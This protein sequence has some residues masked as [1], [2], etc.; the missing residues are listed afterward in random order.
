M[1]HR[2]TSRHRYG[3]GGHYGRDP[4]KK[5]KRK[6]SAYNRFVKAKMK[7][8][9]SMGQA[10]KAWTSQKKGGAAHKSK[11]NKRSYTKSAGKSHKSRKAHR[12]PKVNFKG[13]TKKQARTIR[14]NY[15]SLEL[16]MAKEVRKAIAA[17]RKA[18]QALAHDDRKKLRAAKAEQKAATKKVRAIK[19]ELNSVAAHYHSGGHGYAKH[20][21]SPGLQR[22]PGQE[23]ALAS[24]AHQHESSEASRYNDPGGR[25]PSKAAYKSWS[26]KHKNKG[27]TRAQKKAA[28][29]KHKAALMRAHRAKSKRHGKK[30]R[31]THK[32]T[33]HKKKRK[34]KRSYSKHGMR[35]YGLT[36]G[37]QKYMTRQFKHARRKVRDPGFY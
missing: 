10:A 27:W 16:S 24:W 30:G 4:G 9:M 12:H 1:R 37:Q 23:E 8:G 18:N 36:R 14:K 21:A 26:R 19:S 33:S 31:K 34:A 35:L 20:M 11:A 28:W 22:R 25:A 29:K 7:G 32:K 13:L 17:E 2:R 3:Y 6:L 5:K 15:R